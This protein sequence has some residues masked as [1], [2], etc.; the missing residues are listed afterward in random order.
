MFRKFSLYKLQIYC[1]QAV[2]L[3]W[4]YPSLCFSSSQHP[5]RCASWRRSR[6][7]S[8]SGWKTSLTGEPLPCL[9]NR[10]SLFRYGL[11]GKS[12]VL[13]AVCELAEAGGLTEQGLA[14]RAAQALMLMEYAEEEEALVDYLSAR[15]VGRRSAGQCAAAYTCPL[16]LGSMSSMADL[17]SSLDLQTFAALLQTLPS[18]DVP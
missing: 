13:R 9:I 17:L 6:Q 3:T 16:P 10:L 12:C 5:G 1:L 11:P 4:L 8:T 7:G 15:A 2:V 14:G 18:I